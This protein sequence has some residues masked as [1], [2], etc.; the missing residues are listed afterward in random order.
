MKLNTR[1][2][3]SAFILGLV[4][5]A[6][7]FTANWHLPLLNGAVVTWIE[8]GQALWLLFGAVF[9]VCYI[10]PLSRPAGEKQFWLWAA[11]WWLVLLGRST[12]WGRDYFPEHPKLLFRAISVVLIAM[13]I[14]PVLLSK[15]LRQDIARRLCNEPLP[16]WLLAITV[17][18][19]LISDTVEHHRLLAPV[20]LHNASYGDL[21]EELYELPFMVGLFLMNL[22]FMQRDKQHESAAVCF[23]EPHL[24][25]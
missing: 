18:A 1:L 14:L 10:R 19:F 4:L 9:T 17:C 23:S 7:P 25:K 20:F 6:I 13:I 5:V 3:L 21:I 11:V 22:G 8:N 15:H 16:L 24:A 12:S 2:T